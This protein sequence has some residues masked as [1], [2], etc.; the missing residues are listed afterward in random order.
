[1]AGKNVC[2]NVFVVILSRK[3]NTLEATLYR[4]WFRT[5]KWLEMLFLEVLLLIIVTLHNLKTFHGRT[6][7]P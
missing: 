6:L 7:V 2:N 1:M 5:V 3:Y 4:F